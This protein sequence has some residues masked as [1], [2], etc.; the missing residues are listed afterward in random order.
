MFK[1]SRIMIAALSSGS[2]KTT[3]TCALLQALINRNL[4][5][6]SFKCGADYIDPMFHSKVIGTKSRN[7]DS[8]F[9]NNN[10]LKYLLDKNS[11]GMDISVI[12]G[13]MGYYDGLS[14][15]TLEG[16]SYNIAKIT[17]T[18][19]V[20]VINCRGIGKTIVSVIKGI[21][22]YVSE[23]NIEGVILNEVSSMIYEDI[24]KIIELEV[25]VKVLGYVPKI[26][27]FTLESRHLGLITP[28]EISNIKDKLNEL[29]S[30]VQ[31]TVDIDSII[32]I[33]NKAKELDFKEPQIGKIKDKVRILVARDEAFCFYY[34]DNM[35]ILKRM[36]AEI[37]YFSPIHEEKLPD[38]IDGL[39]IGGG[40]PELYA[41]KLSENKS[42]KE[43]I[44]NKVN[45]GLPTIAECGGFMYLNSTMEDINKNIYDMVGLIEG[46]SYKTEKLGRFGY[47]NLTPYKDNF[48]LLKDEEIRGHEFHYFDSTACGS[49][50]NAKKPLRSRNWDCINISENLFAGYPHI[51]FYSNLNFPYNFLKKCNEF[52]ERGNDY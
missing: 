49:D 36:G 35:D 5:V 31:E 12:E 8:F 50:F 33:S 34:E 3:I 27:T 9:C 19:V 11:K 41:K 2:G 4:K 22:E 16:S 21:K 10:D 25:K 40:Y 37:L 39:I 44:Y 30:I 6:A 17:D 46:H 32:S 13:V 42:M 43:S 15:S 51:H 52:R 23:S 14:V 20:L 38:D 28:N 29:A 26:T 7:L 48:L 47:I 45:M 18:P 24:K 1:G